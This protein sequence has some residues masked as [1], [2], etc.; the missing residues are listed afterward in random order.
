MAIVKP[1][2]GVRPSRDKVALVSSKSY[3][4]Y[5]QEELSAKLNL[6]PFSFLHVVN[7]GYKYHHEDITGEKRFKL[8]YNRYLEFKEEH[9]FNQ[10][11]TPS[12]YI[13]Q[14]TKPDG[15]TYCGIISSVAASEYHNNHIKIH[16]KTLASR[17][18]MFENYLKNTGFNPEPV[19]LTYPD[20]DII[21]NIIKKY[22]EERAEY[23]FSSMDKDLHLLWVVDKKEDM[24]I[25]EKEFG[26]VDTLY[27]ADGHHRTTSSCLLAKHMA[28]Q[29]PNH[30]GN[31]PYNYFLSYLLPA[32][33]I[34]VFEFNRFIKSI[35]GLTADELLIE[36]DTYFKIEN[37]GLSLYKPTK[38]YHFSM[39]LEG[40]FYELK[41]RESAYQF[42]DSLSR[43][44]AQILYN[45]V[46]KPILG[47][48][49]IRDNSKIV[50]SQDK[51]DGLELKTKVDSGEFEV[52]F[53][54]KPSSVREIKKI[55]DDG[56]VMPPKTTY[57]EPKLRSGL[58]IYEL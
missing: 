58:I 25:I 37:K 2:K 56:L 6:N 23:E 54:M 53:G 55:V 20:N 32:S 47:I 27:I 14:K 18:V 44:D 34:S 40:S 42:S 9:I 7:P 38:K 45:T 16:E 39:Y 21:E 19:L 49:D 24:E 17:E 3:E 41:L 1:F 4:A 22:K 43:L 12:F 33:Q 28:E 36:L 51:S 31:E 5:T 52:S 48:D 57:I 13:Y 11:E 15:T 10:D 26:K 29:N 8:V 35:N 50:Y 46:L 30:T